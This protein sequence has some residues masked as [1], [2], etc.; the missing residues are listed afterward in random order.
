MIIFTSVL[1]L[2]NGGGVFRGPDLAN[3]AVF[4]GIVFCYANCW[5]A[6]VCLTSNESSF[7]ILFPALSSVV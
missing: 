6:S 1:V 3:V 7:V 4:K 5:F 2:F